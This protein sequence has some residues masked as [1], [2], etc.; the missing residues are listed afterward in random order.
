MPCRKCWCLCDP[1]GGPLLV[2]PGSCQPLLLEELMNLYSHGMCTKLANF[3]LYCSSMM[4]PSLHDTL[5]LY[6]KDT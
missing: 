5:G 2:G 4:S 6:W 3:L 1:A